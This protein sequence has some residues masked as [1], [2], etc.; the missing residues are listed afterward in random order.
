MEGLCVGLV[1][2]M[3]L[4]GCNQRSHRSWPRNSLPHMFPK[5]LNYPFNGYGKTPITK[6]SPNA[7]STNVCVFVC[8]H[9][10]VSV[11]SAAQLNVLLAGATFCFVRRSL[12]DGKRQNKRFTP[13]DIKMV[14]LPSTTISIS[15]RHHRS[16]SL[17]C[18]FDSSVCLYLRGT[19]EVYV[20]ERVL[21]PGADVGEQ[22]TV[23]RQPLSFLRQC[24]LKLIR[25]KSDW[26]F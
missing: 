25:K 6:G 1:I 13:T 11:N 5:I 15:N 19:C 22:G 23:T 10:C 21:T 24:S 4:P 16:L 9:V 3:R 7:I 14:P 17:P 18:F 2:T 20:R 12:P 8:V 26:Y